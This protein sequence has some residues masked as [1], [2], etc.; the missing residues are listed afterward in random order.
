MT[1]RYVLGI[2][3]L[4]AVIAAGAY[5]LLGQRRPPAPA[6]TAEVHGHSA[7]AASP[8]TAAARGAV[9][10]D[11]RR[12]QLIGVRTAIVRRASLD[13]T[14]R[15]AGTVVVD[16]TR[17]SEISTHVD[18]W[19]REL[20]ADFTGR[21]IRRGEPL[22]TLYSPDVIATQQEF[23]LAL[24]GRATSNPGDVI[25]RE[26]ADRLV[27]AARERLLRLDMPPQDVDQ[28]ERTGKTAE[29]ITFA[30]PVTGTIVEKTAVRGM[31]VM[32]GQTLYRVAD[33]STVWVEAE[34]YE[35]DLA[36]M[37]PGVRATVSFGA[38]PRRT[39]AGRISFVAPTIT[40]ETRTARV[41]V[42]MANPGGLL[43]PNMLAEVSVETPATPSL[44]VPTDAVVNTG[45]DTLAFVAEGE[46][47][48]TPRR[49][50]IG[51]TTP[52]G[53]EV[54]SGLN[55]G[56][57]VATSATFFLDSE[58][59]LRGALQNYEPPSNPAAA[60]A[61]PNTTALDVTF[62]SDPEL[63]T[64]GDVTLIVTVKAA[65]R[66]V[67]DAEVSVVLSMPGMPSMN[68]PAMRAQ[69]TLPSVGEGTYRG[70]GQVMTPGRWDIAVSVRRHG[71]SLGTRQFALIVR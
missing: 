18:G 71:Q 19:I 7:T 69:A 13:D 43:K 68:M 4:A 45:T 35:A 37:R 34:A 54:L 58:S 27:A 28:L 64:P 5:V 9:E 67:T 62:R 12:Q 11:T 51:R 49:V 25:G 41:R 53:V 42:A 1:K 17:Q 14:I 48:F 30:S 60:P 46:G 10:L 29:A 39:F 57:T 21:V 32:A 6:V 70:T 22:F 8:A 65:G 31:R 15:L 16:E 26:Y 44:I 50:R 40:A 36:S 33:L 3:I 52:D 59:Q 55:D 47:R 23:L 2:L 61:A 66:P 56:D 20:S 24:R 38:Y 63:P